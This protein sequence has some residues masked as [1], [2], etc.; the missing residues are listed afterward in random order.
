MKSLLEYYPNRNDRDFSLGQ[1]ISST[2]EEGAHVQTFLDR[3]EIDSRAYYW[4]IFDHS[5]RDWTM[6]IRRNLRYVHLR[7]WQKLWYQWVFRLDLKRR[8]IFIRV[9]KTIYNWFHVWLFCPINKPVRKPAEL[10][11]RICL[12][13][14]WRC[15]FDKY[16]QHD[17]KKDKQSTWES[18]LAFVF[19]TSKA[20][21]VREFE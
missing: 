19:V 15:L 9:R 11:T 2:D 8:R 13:I 4:N 16:F 1:S 6:S 17:L 18:S 14:F 10:P 5:N 21:C 7:T 12:K 3:N 20:E